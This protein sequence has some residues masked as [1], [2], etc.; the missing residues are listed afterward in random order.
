MNTTTDL[1]PFMYFGKPQQLQQLEQIFEEW[2]DV[3]AALR[4]STDEL[5]KLNQYMQENKSRF[6]SIICNFFGFRHLDLRL[7]SIDKEVMSTE[8]HHAYVVE[9]VFPVEYYRCYQDICEIRDKNFLN[10]MKRK[11]CNID[12]ALK[13]DEDMS[14]DTKLAWE[15]VAKSFRALADSYSQYITDLFDQFHK[16]YPKQNMEYQ[17]RYFFDE[18]GRKHGSSLDGLLIIDCLNGLKFNK[19]KVVIDMNLNISTGMLRHPEFTSDLITASVLHEIGHNL[20]DFIV[21]PDKQLKRIKITK[22]AEELFADRFASMYGYGPELARTFQLF[23]D[24][25]NMKKSDLEVRRLKYNLSLPDKNLMIIKLNKNISIDPHPVF[26]NR[27]YQIINHLKDNLHSPYL[28][29][30]QRIELRNDYKQARQVLA[31]I[32]KNDKLDDRSMTLSKY[33]Y[34]MM[35]LETTKNQDYMI[36]CKEVRP[37]RTRHLLSNKDYIYDDVYRQLVKTNDVQLEYSDSAN[38]K[39]DDKSETNSDVS[40]D[41]VSDC[42]RSNNTST[43]N[44]YE[45]H[46]NL[47]ESCKDTTK[48]DNKSSEATSVTPP[49]TS[50]DPLI[51]K[52]SILVNHATATNKYRLYDNFNEFCENI[53]TPEEWVEWFKQTKH[54]FSHQ[55]NDKYMTWPD[56]LVAGE[57]SICVDHAFF[58]YLWAEKKGLRSRLLMTGFRYENKPNA[59]THV[60]PVLMRYKSKVIV[61]DIAGEHCE[62]SYLSYYDSFKDFKEKFNSKEFLST[63]KQNDP[64]LTH[65]AWAWATKYDMEAL[66]PYINQKIIQRTFLNKMVGVQVIRHQ[67]DHINRNVF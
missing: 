34:Q 15:K 67:I 6:E 27:I 28:S 61:M 30:K 52:K 22:K 25:Y 56:A 20:A 50:N 47:N 33:H 21:R 36:G 41:T 8:I 5:S 65:F 54:T 18:A 24:S 29:Q 58:G 60:A 46:D 62:N 35:K 53:D 26:L 14:V 4:D 2:K 66:V 42:N 48:D 37:L 23:K 13:Y 55:G 10:I 31:R 9:P 49:S 45:S 39:V 32:R 44:K 19:D 16:K 63:L 57:P 17:V 3:A 1:I 59:D 43:V 12:N 40:N 7:I 38:T 51:V 11:A 64:N